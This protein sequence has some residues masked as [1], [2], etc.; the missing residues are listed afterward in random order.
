MG[1]L[2][3]DTRREVRLEVPPSAE[4]LRV[5]RLVAAEAGAR[6]GLDVEATDDLR[7][8]VDELCHVLVPRAVTRICIRF[9]VQP[10]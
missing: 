5:V 3:V 6:A 4:H 9:H 2:P 10:C 1:E 7:I 8:A